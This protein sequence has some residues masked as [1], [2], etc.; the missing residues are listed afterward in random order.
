MTIAYQDERVLYIRNA[1]GGGSLAPRAAASVEGT[2]IRRFDR[3]RECRSGQ[4]HR[5]SAIIGMLSG[6]V[7]TPPQ[8][9]GF[10]NLGLGRRWRELHIKSA[11]SSK[12][13][14]QIRS[15][16]RLMRS[17]LRVRNLHD[18][19]LLTKIR[20]RSMQNMTGYI[21][22]NSHAGKLRADKRGRCDCV[23]GTSERVHQRWRGVSLCRCAGW[24]GK[25]VGI[26]RPQQ[27]FE[28]EGGAVMTAVIIDFAARH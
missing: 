12:P 24:E 1:T 17:R 27:V 5:L 11:Q 20:R 2:L 19:R 10:R 15:S 7:G 18:T 23:S 13:V 25:A 22:S 14:E 3:R 26:F 8:S 9:A 16:L 6:C 28:Q 4:N 21:T